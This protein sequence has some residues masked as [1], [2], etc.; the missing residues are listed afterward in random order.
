MSHRGGEYVFA[1]MC[2][3]RLSNQ[4]GESL[5]HRRAK[6]QAKLYSKELHTASWM[7]CGQNLG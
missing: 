6:I 1:E 7:L 4:I 3:G 5:R 2:G